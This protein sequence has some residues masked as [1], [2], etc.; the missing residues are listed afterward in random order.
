MSALGPSRWLR[1]AQIIIPGEPH[2]EVATSC[3][4]E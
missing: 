3:L 4:V 1:I 2:Q